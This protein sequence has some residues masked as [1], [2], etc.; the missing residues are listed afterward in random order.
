[1]RIRPLL[2][3]LHMHQLPPSL[4]YCIALALLCGCGESEVVEDTAI[5]E[6]FLELHQEVY[7]VY[8][9]PLDRDV[10]WD[11]LA[12]SFEGEALTQQY[13]EHWS[14]KHR[15]RAEET[16]IQIRKVDYGAVPVVS[17]DPEGG[18]IDASWSVGGIVT[19]QGHQHPRVNR[20]RALYRIENTVSGWRIVASHS[21]DVARVKSP[22]R[23]TDVFEVLDGAQEGGGYLDPLDLLDGL[24]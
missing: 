18:W 5:Q 10:V 21:R 22:S 4:P 1:M 23:T 15:M 3:L 17:T 9:L 7:G 2:E 19:H 11:W 14:T 12:K 24:D 6:A 8:D 20:Y 13:V 16:S